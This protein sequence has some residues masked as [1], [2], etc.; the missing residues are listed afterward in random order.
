MKK[1][2]FVMFIV[3]LIVLSVACSGKDG[4]EINNISYTMN[5]VLED[6]TLEGQQL[7]SITNTYMEG[8]DNLVFNLYANAYSESTVDKAYA[9]KLTKYGGIDIDSITVGGVVCKN[10]KLSENGQTLTVPMPALALNDSID[11]VMEYTVTIPESNLRLGI[12]GNSY[13]LANFYPQVAVFEDG[14]FRQD[15]FTTIGDPMFSEVANYEVT[16]TASKDIVIASSAQVVSENVNGKLK[17]TLYKGA[18][19]RDFAIAANKDFKTVKGNYNDTVVTYYYTID[20]NSAA[21]LDYAMSALKTFSESFGEYPY[22]TFSIVQTPFYSGGMEFS[23]LI[24]VADDVKDVQTTVIHE[25]AHQWWYG[26]VGSDSINESYLDEGLTTFVTAYYFM[27]NDDAERYSAEISTSVDAYMLYEK[28]QKMRKTTST[29]VMTKSLYDYT[30]YQYN[31]LAYN[32]G[33][34]MFMS[35]YNTL[36]K[37]KF[38]K[39]LNL[40]LHNNKYKIANTETLCRAFSAAGKNEYAG[41]I[42]GW[43]GDNVLAT[44]A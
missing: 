25:T 43:L 1:I 28:M 22:P 38:N 20:N 44:F 5:L 9:S 21:T 14:K 3:V 32:K 6:N 37:D 41:F 34:M 29:L 26:M 19:I 33:C 27:L 7:V 10:F 16:I 39:A 24:F 13:N 11:I 4:E 8:L 2:I 35:L 31:M 30:A 36:G 23:S 15:K 17:T 40:Y 18:N 12:K 42:N